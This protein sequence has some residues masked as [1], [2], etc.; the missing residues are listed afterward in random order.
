MEKRAG[1]TEEG[2]ERERERKRKRER[3]ILNGTF[4]PSFFSR[5]STLHFSPRCV[6]DRVN[7]SKLYIV[8]HDILVRIR[9]IHMKGTEGLMRGTQKVWL[10]PA[11][12]IRSVAQNEAVNKRAVI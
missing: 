4:P 5:P 12:L 6:H 10:N 2:R 1:E 8:R 3:R 9:Q 11:L 7:S